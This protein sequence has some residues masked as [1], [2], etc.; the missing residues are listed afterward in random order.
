MKTIIKIFIFLSVQL[1]YSQYPI[2]STTSLSNNPTEDPNFNKIG[3]YAVDTN[4]ERNQYVG[5]WQYETAEITF[6]LKI[7]KRDQYLFKTVIPSEDIFIYDYSDVVIFKY[8]LI[9]NGIVIFDNLNSTIPDDS[10]LSTATKNGNYEY[11]SGLM[12]DQ[13]RNV[14]ASVEIKKLNSTNPEQIEFDLSSGAYHLL[15]DDSYYEGSGIKLFNI[16]TDGI[17]MEKVN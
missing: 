4:N 3:N 13:T 10:Y 11:L 16:P 15:N 14:R 8:K 1:S 5:L 17:V 12:V 6:Q 9:K 7:E 2:L